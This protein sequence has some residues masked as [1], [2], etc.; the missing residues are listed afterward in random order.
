MKR[1]IFIAGCSGHARVVYDVLRS[2]GRFEVIGFIDPVVAS[3]TVVDGIPVL[4]TDKNIGSIIKSHNLQ[5][6]IVGIGNNR[7]RELVAQKIKNKFHELD[8]VTAV[9][10][11]ATVA[12]G[13]QL[14]AGTV[15]MAQ[16]TINIGSTIED[17][18]IINTGALVDHDCILKEYSSIAPGA[19]LGGNCK[20]DCRSFIGLG[21]NVIHGCQLGRDV[22]VGAGSLVLTDF[23]SYTLVYGSPARY[24]RKRKIDDIYL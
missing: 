1:R 20:I 5:G 2:E 4:G 14:G 11:T 15:L 23:P 21:S 12:K 9:H 17:G 6:F 8:Y 10:P 22:V 19:V 7:R 24:I 18:C 3:G 16:A 13:V